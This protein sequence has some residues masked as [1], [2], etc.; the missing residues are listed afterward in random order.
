MGYMGLGMQRWIYNHKIRRPFKYREGRGGYD[1][2][3]LK[4]RNFRLADTPTTDEKKI[5]EKID[6]SRHILRHNILIGKLHSFIYIASILLISVASIFSIRYFSRS[7][8]NNYPGNIIERRNQEKETAVKILLKSGKFYLDNNDLEYALR[9]FGQ[10]ANIAPD[11]PRAIA[12]YVLALALDC[13]FNQKNCE[14]ALEYYNSL[15]NLDEGFITL[16]IKNRMQL[17]EELLE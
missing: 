15:R 10:A 17:I 11:N 2:I 8:A 16:E 5:Q 7:A 6:S 13:E 14:R 9:E 3:D 12:Y 4:T 1:S